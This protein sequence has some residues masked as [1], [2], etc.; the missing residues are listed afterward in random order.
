[1]GFIEEREREKGSVGEGEMYGRRVQG[2][3][4]WRE[5]MGRRNGCLE[6]PLTKEETDARAS[7]GVGW[8]LHGR[9]RLGWLQAQSWARSRS[10]L[11][12]S[13]VARGRGRERGALGVAQC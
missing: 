12:C 5:V 3:H 6:A 8:R 1:V 4:Q 10:R 9:G 7:V 11:S 13:V 2:G